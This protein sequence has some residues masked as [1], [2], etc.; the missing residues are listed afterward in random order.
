MVPIRSKG[1]IQLIAVAII[2]Y[3]GDFD[4][5]PG[6]HVLNLQTSLTAIKQLTVCLV[7]HM[8]TLIS[9]SLLQPRLALQSTASGSLVVPGCHSVVRTVPK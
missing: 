9:N 8:Q 7:D 6:V 5:S 4:S 3:M 2:V 1:S